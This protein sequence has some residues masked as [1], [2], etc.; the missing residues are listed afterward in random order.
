MFWVCDWAK[1][2]CWDVTVQVYK[3]LGSVKKNLN[4][5]NL[6][7]HASLNYSLFKKNRNP[8]VLGV[9]PA[10]KKGLCLDFF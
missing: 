4:N 5:I 10:S 8:V 9:F 1:D 7:L 6:I 2:Q 3:L